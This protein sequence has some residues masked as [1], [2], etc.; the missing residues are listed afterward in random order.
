MKRIINIILAATALLAFAPISSAQL[1][2]AEKQR[3]YYKDSGMGLAYSKTITPPS[4][5]GI[6]R[7]YLESFVTGE[8]KMKYEDAPAD[9]ILVLD[10][11][12]SMSDV[13]GTKTLVTSETELSYNTIIN[14]D[15]AYLAHYDRNTGTGRPNNYNGNYRSFKEIDAIKIG[16]RYYLYIASYGDGASGSSN[17]QHYHFL[18]ADG[19]GIVMTSYANSSSLTNPP[20]NA[21][22]A[23][24]PD[25]AIVIYPGSNSTTYTDAGENTSG[26]GNDRSLYTGSSRMSDLKDAVIAFIDEIN[27][28]D[29]YGEDE[30]GNTIERDHRLGNRLSI[31]TF[32]GNGD[33]K[34]IFPLTF[35][36]DTSTTLDDMK[37][38][39]KAMTMSQGTYPGPGFQL[40]NTQLSSIEAD[41]KKK[42]S[43]T[44]VFFTDGE[45]AD[46][47]DDAAISQSKTSK[48][49]HT[50][51]VYS[52]ALFD[53]APTGENL[54]FLHRVSS[55]YPH[56]TNNNAGAAGAGAD[57]SDDKGYYK[58]ASQGQDLTEIFR[59]IAQESGGTGN[60]SLGSAVA[61]VDVVSAS[62][63]IPEGATNDIHIYTAPVIGIQEG[64]ANADTTYTVSVDGENVTRHWLKF[65]DPIPIKQNTAQYEQLGDD[66]KPVEPTVWVDVDENI[67]YTLTPASKPNTIKVTGFDY[68]GNWCGEYLDINGN[69]EDPRRFHGHKVIIEIPIKMSPSAVGGPNVE[70]NAPGSGI[71]VNGES[72]T[73]LIRF[74]SPS[75]SLPLNIW[76]Q[77]NG[78]DGGES[79]K[80]TIQ[81]KLA[82]DTSSSGW[83][84]VTSVFVTQTKGSTDAPITK[85][86]GLPSTDSQDRPFVYRIKEEGWSWSYTPD[87]EYMLS[88]DIITNPF[89]FSNSKIDEDVDTKIRHAESKATNSFTTKS[90]V[91]KTTYD[92]SKTNTRS[93]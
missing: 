39:V 79:S 85:V 33:Q 4:P 54:R 81:R 32:A 86:M 78:L 23:T 72:T 55:D 2:P 84:D 29:L 61:A 87:K 91:Q 45:P 82:S 18:R 14:A 80:F 65:G 36:D 12:T 63:E 27:K 90:G 71:Y 46:G 13:R 43:R 66:G 59:K 52:V 75:V 19:N 74:E 50:A 70:T 6:Y 38:N 1:T 62:F 11:S 17:G 25:A 56:A 57:G 28:N 5:D 15:H 8:V 69:S 20:T 49:E 47:Q 7:I 3:I 60:A 22:Y 68:S 44:I 58:D 26:I 76:I 42:S 77:K 83:E 37:A 88:T 24:D 34:T 92:D 30:D 93:N 9:I 10:V 67:S 51:I 40:A 31:I 48:E 64:I 35:L 89:I 73:P 16:D 41:R 53:S 21:A